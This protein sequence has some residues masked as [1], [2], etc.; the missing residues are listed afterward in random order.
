[1]K[2]LVIHGAEDIRLEEQPVPEVVAGQVR[3]RVQYV[4]IC[5]SDLHYYYLGRNGENHVREPFVPGHELS[6][7]VDLDPSGELA[8]G[9]PVTV[10]P[11]RYGPEVAGLQDRPHLWPGG[12]Y[13]GSAGVFPHRQ[14]AATELLVV[15]RDMVRVLPEGLPLRRAALAEPLAV[16]IHAVV[17]AGDVSGK[18]ALV[19]GAGPIGLLAVAALRRAGASEIVVGDVRPEP[20]ARAEA[21]GATRTVLVTEEQIEPGSFPVVL[22]CSAAPVSLG[23]AVRA[24]A[25]GGIVVQV[26]ILPDQEI[27]VNLAPLLAKEAELRGTFRFST[28]ID[29]AIALLAEDP[30]LEDVVTQVVPAADATDAFA[31]ARDAARSAKVLLAL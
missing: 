15:D 10:H 14:G 3:L 29:D 11:A 19:L 13:L 30:S 25:P 24:V 26:G 18:P 1:M 23:S 20:L 31:T 21:L 9:T 4:G 28:E 2:S 7:T 22:E 12:D 6:A 5:G 27:S 8:P 16:S 17:I